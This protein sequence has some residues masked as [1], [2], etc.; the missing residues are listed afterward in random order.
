VGATLSSS[1]RRNLDGVIIKLAPKKI[2]GQGYT[3]PT[4]KIPSARR[5]TAEP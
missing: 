5:P 4:G 3:R 1:Y 2:K